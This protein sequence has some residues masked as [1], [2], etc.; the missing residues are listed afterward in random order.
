MKTS[1][2]LNKD[3]LSITALIKDNYPELVKFLEEMPLDSTEISSDEIE[4]DH[5]Q[6]YYESLS[7]MVKEY[8]ETH[9]SI[10][11]KNMN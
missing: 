1:Q 9:D 7:K 10:S 5:L 11:M 4:G 3:I 2:Q 6:E 8:A